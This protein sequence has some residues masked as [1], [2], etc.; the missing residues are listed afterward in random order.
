MPGV[1]VNSPK[2]KCALLS[3]V[4]C[5]YHLIFFNLNKARGIHKQK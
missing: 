1:E 2:T 4:L 3:L 5:K